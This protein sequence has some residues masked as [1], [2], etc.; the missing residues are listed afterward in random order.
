[1]NVEVKATGCDTL[2]VKF[3]V[4]LPPNPMPNTSLPCE[5]N[6]ASVYLQS[7]EVKS[8][9]IIGAGGTQTK[10]IPLNGY[11]ATGVKCITGLASNT[12]FRV[13]Y[14][15]EVDVSSSTVLPSDLAAPVELFTGRTCNPRN[16]CNDT[17]IAR[18]CKLYI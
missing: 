14:G 10:R 8:R 3:T 4:N 18:K 9:P 15:V 12:P 13:T 6:M 7:L 5:D 16:Q 1:M 11:P 2:Q 17:I